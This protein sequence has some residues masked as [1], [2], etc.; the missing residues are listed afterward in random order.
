MN[1]PARFMVFKGKEKLGACRA[2]QVRPGEVVHTPG[3]IF[4]ELSLSRRG[5]LPALCSGDEPQCSPRAGWG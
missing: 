2:E 1:S 3:F 5:S 4:P